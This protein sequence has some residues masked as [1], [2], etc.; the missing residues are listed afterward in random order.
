VPR[1]SFLTTTSLIATRGC[2]NR[3]GFCYL[4]TKG[5]KMPYLVRDVEQVAR[6]FAD[7]DQPYGVFIDNNLG[8]EPDYLRRLCRELR[9]LGKIWS[10]A[11]TID[12]TD[13]PSLVRDMALGGCTGV[14]VGFESLEDANLSDARKRTPKCDDYSRR[15]RILHDNGIQVNG[16]FVLGFDHDRRDV[17]QRTADWIERNRLECATFHIMTPYPATP[18]FRQMESEGRLLHKNWSLYDTAHVVFRPRH[19]SPDELAAGYAWLYE[20]LF[21]HASIW[22]R[23][24]LDPRAVPPYLAMSYLYKRSNRFWRFLIQHE[25]TSSVWRPLVEMSRRRH[26]A[27]RSELDARPAPPRPA[28]RSLAVVSAGV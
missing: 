8:S 10:A 17:F 7:D 19:M 21:S 6:E 11:V 9:P 18:L 5:L 1:K 22:K 24:P 14:F 3:C 27:F 15:V 16:S 2:H 12:V 28:R 20:R 26:L 25:L 13:D 4:S 23:R